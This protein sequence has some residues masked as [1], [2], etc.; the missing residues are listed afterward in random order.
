MLFKNVRRSIFGDDAKAI[1]KLGII[2]PSAEEYDQLIMVNDGLL[3]VQSFLV[4][5]YNQRFYVTNSSGMLLY[6]IKQLYGMI[7]DTYVIYDAFDVELGKIVAKVEMLAPGYNVNIYGKSNFTVEKISDPHHQDYVALGLHMV[8]QGDYLNLDY[9]ACSYDGQV[10]GEVKTK[11][12]GDLLNAVIKLESNDY[13]LEV[14]C[15][16]ACAILSRL[17][18]K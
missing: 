18:M 15:S 5:A 13:Q 9:E 16:C 1:R 6:K 7:P 11:T 17:V 4:E 12:P 3:N 8:F 10:L 2:V 14:I